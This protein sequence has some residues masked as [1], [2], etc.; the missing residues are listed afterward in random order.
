MNHMKLRHMGA[1][2]ILCS[3]IVSLGGQV[4]AL[5]VFPLKESANARYL[6]D[7][8]NTPFLM[9]GDS[10]Q[11][12]IGNLSE[13]DAAYF[14]ANRVQYGINALWINLLCDSYTACNADGT[15]FD[16]IAPFTTPGDL[17]TPNP[18]YF[19][20]A[21]DIINLAAAR[22]VVVLLDPIETGGWLPVLEANGVKKARAYGR[23]LARR[24]A[25]YPNIVWMSGNDFQSWRN[26]ADDAVVSAVA[27]GIQDKD[28][29]HIHSI[30]LDYYVSAS[31][32]DKAWRPIVGL[33][34]VYTYRPTYAK[35]LDEYKK[36]KFKPTFL[37]EANYEFEHNGGTDGGTTQ[38][39][40]RQ[41]YWTALS[42][43]SGQLYGSAYSWRLQNDWKDNLDTVGIRQLSYMQQLFTARRW[44]DLVPD[45][46]H[47]VV[48]K[49]YGQFSEDD[50]IPDDTYATA[51]STSD[52]TLAIAYLPDIRTVTI[53]MAKFSAQVT[54]HWFDPTNNSFTAIGSFTNAGK[55]RFTPPGK[56]GDGD[57]DWV[58]LLE[59]N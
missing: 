28:A 29:E 37:V 35:E 7:Q 8:D 51:A 31:L 6:V 56:N 40:R 47:Q 23:F 48:V 57:E 24:F 21:A 58:L 38:N 25:D 11:A 43:T 39:L 17:S 45:R 42:G 50:P 53:N 20:R 18:D 26:P 32:D 22:G 19:D 46:K 5:P 27:K 30:E 41:E 52:G 3:I 12:M 13:D 1:T 49:G 44:F 36:A 34:A 59:A 55:H 33:D 10:P 4:V 54:A 16:G 9:V 14:I 15:T 2:T